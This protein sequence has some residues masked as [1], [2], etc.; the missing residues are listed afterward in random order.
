MILMLPGS[1]GSRSVDK[2][3]AKFPEGNN[4]SALAT[5]CHTKQNELSVIIFVTM[6][7][8]GLMTTKMT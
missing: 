4:L 3:G 8:G 5:E 1:Q 7:N 6:G 2:G